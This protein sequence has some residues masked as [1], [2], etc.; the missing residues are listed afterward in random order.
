MSGIAIYEGVVTHQRLRPVTHR[1]KYNVYSFLF[2]LET[3]DADIAG[4]RWVSRNRPNVFSFYDRDH[5]DG[6]GADLLTA[7]RAKLRGAG[8]AGDGKVLLLCYPRLLG[9]VFNP[10]SIYYC[11]DR[12][13]A[14]EAVLYEVNNTFGGRHSYLIGAANGGERIEQSTDKLFHV[15]PFI[16]ME[17]RYRFSITQ[18]GENVRLSINVDDA[19]GVLLNAR[20]GGVRT[21]VSDRALV[22]LFF[23]YPLMTLK[24]I[25]GIHV[26]AVKL[27]AKGLRLRAGAEPE[28][29][30]TVV[31]APVKAAA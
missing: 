25:V 13:G 15:S 16:D 4:L 9:Y 24:I 21:A 7:V 28:H 27:M 2:D 5:G 23:R 31:N 30:M 12:T 8:F 22:S 1:L 29:R 26:E 18:P 19:D 3:I 14:L 11:Y 10:L 20:F 6:A 17:M